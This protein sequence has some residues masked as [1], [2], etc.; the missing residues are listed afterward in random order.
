MAINST[1]YALINICQSLTHFLKHNAYTVDIIS[2]IS[3]EVR[4]DLELPDL[5]AQVLLFWAQMSSLGGEHRPG[6]LY[7]IQHFWVVEMQERVGGRVGAQTHMGLTSQRWFP[8]KQM[9]FPA[10]HVSFQ[11]WATFEC[12]GSNASAFLYSAVFKSIMI[13]WRYFHRRKA[14]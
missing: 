6:Y 7:I 9:I 10:L 13:Y 1:I 2:P 4:G 11:L 12:T 8:E 14:T 3:K 5:E